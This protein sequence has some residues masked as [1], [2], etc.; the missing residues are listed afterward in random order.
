VARRIKSDIALR[1]RRAGMRRVLAITVLEALDRDKKPKFGAHIVAGMRDATTRDR[2]IESLNV[3]TAYGSA[4]VVAEPVKDWPGLTSY[5]LKEATPQAWYGAGKGF[6][7][8]GFHRLSSLGC[9]REIED[10]A[11]DRTADAEATNDDVRDL[12]SG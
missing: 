4:T 3:S 11:G 2:L 1:Q 12:G 7:R 10:A 6:R 8:G 5:L 9:P